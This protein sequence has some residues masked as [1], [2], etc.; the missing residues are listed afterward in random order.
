MSH[1]SYSTVKCIILF[2]YDY[3]KESVLLSYTSIKHVHSDVTFHVTCM[4]LDIFYAFY[5]YTNACYEKLNH[6]HGQETVLLMCVQL[7]ASL[8]IQEFT[9]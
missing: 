2:S 1:G 4:N 7:L 8:I 6:D 9:S 3:V 5:M